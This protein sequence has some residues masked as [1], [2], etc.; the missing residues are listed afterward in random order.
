[1]GFS[2][3]AAAWFGL[4]RE[5]SVR[6]SARPPV[7]GRCLSTSPL[8]AVR[9][10]QAYN[11][12]STPLTA[13]TSIHTVRARVP[14]HLAVGCVHGR[15]GSGHPAGRHDDD[16]APTLAPKAGSRD[17]DAE[18]PQTV[19]RCPA[20]AASGCPTVGTRDSVRAGGALA[21]RDLDRLVELGRSSRGHQ[22]APRRLAREPA[23]V[24]A[25]PRRPAC[26]DLALCARE[27]LIS[28]RRGI[29][30]RSRARFAEEATCRRRRSFGSVES[31]G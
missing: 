13:V 2:C 27:V 15:Q 14:L 22:R 24:T 12:R 30:A 17:S 18:A 29:L 3:L 1:L 19:E 5:L 6:A 9:P 26:R 23:R 20:C 16:S 8:T 21:A 28:P 7:A 11:S 4:K 31:A 25:E 10:S